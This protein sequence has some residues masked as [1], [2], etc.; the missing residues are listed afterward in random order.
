MR[1]LI[2]D[3]VHERLIEGL[4]Q[5][6]IE[7]DYKPDAL[8]SEVIACI[9][10]YEGLVVRT[11]MEISRTVL[12]QATILQFIARAGAGL[13]NRPEITNTNPATIDG[14]PTSR[15]MLLSG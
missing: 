6:G 15:A 2:I 10:Q 14:K 9:S 8:P 7:V 3:D 5:L 4:K 1:V 12:S 11:K 13:D